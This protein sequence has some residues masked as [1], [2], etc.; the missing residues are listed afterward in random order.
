MLGPAALGYEEGDR[1][2]LA[3]SKVLAGRSRDIVYPSS[4]EHEVASEAYLN[5]KLGSIPDHGKYQRG[6][7]FWH[8][9]GS[10]QHLLPRRVL[11]LAATRLPY[12]VRRE[13][14]S[15]DRGNLKPLQMQIGKSG[16]F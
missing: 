8:Y 15:V 2:L 9:S 5:F 10:R 3:D 11:R 1:G 7:H 4:I 6:F 13:C 14:I 12:C 16:A